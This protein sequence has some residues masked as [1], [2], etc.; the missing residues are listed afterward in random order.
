MKKFFFTNVKYKWLLHLLA[1]AI[2]FVVPYIFADSH[3]KRPV[4]GIKRDEFQTF[5]TLTDLFWVLIFYLNAFVLI[6]AFFYSRRFLRYVAFLLLIFIGLMG[7]HVALFYLMYRPNTIH[8]WVAAYHNILPFLFT[9]ALSATYKTISDRM[10]T[11]KLEKERQSENL[12]TELAFLRS[13]ISPH[14]LFNVLNNIA[15]L[16][17]IKSDELEPTILK[18]SSLM[19][20]M[21]YETDEEKVPI[22]QEVEYMHDYI[23]LQKQRFGEE[24]HFDAQFD[25]RENWHSIEPML[26]IPFVENAFKHGGGM[27]PGPDISLRLSV[28]NNKLYFTVRNRFESAPAV[29]DKTSGIGLSNVKRRLKLLYP[30]K[31]EL[32]INNQDGWFTIQLKLEVS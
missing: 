30:G 26:L 8:F 29:K 28:D 14:F 21:L 5:D 10:E 19:R 3:G 32:N 23:D 4:G 20:Y 15:A 27:M 31:H 12:K 25:I 11:E 13:Q 16:A 7:I 22:V 2:I 18:L 6:P 9:I 17:R 1:W 24:L